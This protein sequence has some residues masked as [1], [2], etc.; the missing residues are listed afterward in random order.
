MDDL[1]AHIQRLE[2]CV[3]DNLLHDISYE[4]HWWRVL[5]FLELAGNAGMVVNPEKFQ[6]GEDTVDFAGFKISPNTVEPLP[7]YLLSIANFPT[8]ED[9]SDLRKRLVWFS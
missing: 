9:I 6:F 4:D 3:D 2:R 5:D 1:P 7:K 8:P